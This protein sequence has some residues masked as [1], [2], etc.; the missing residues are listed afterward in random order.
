M[1]LT[2]LRTRNKLLDS[3][4]LQLFLDEEKKL[5]VILSNDVLKAFY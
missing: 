3:L 2:T 1:T 5:N 4:E